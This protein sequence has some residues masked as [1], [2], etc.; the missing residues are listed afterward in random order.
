MLI[1]GRQGLYEGTTVIKL[2]ETVSGE[3]GKEE[4]RRETEGTKNSYGRQCHVFTKFSVSFQD[5]SLTLPLNHKC[6][7]RASLKFHK[8]NKHVLVR[9]SFQ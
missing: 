1:L 6:F 2:C 8:E 4:G 5:F 3:D 9:G 7:V